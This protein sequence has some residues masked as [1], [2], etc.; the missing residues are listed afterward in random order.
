MT[1]RVLGLIC[2]ICYISLP[3]LSQNIGEE[4]YNRA[5]RFKDSSRWD[6][7]VFYFDKAIN[8]FEEKGLVNQAFESKLMLSSSRIEA[9]QFK[10]A[11][12]DLS[13]LLSESRKALPPRTLE[14][15]QVLD[16][17][18]KLAIELGEFSQAVIKLRESLAIKRQAKL[19]DD[20]MGLTY[21]RF[22][23]AWRAQGIIDSA[24][25]A[26]ES[27]KHI[28][29]GL[30]GEESSEVAA[31]WSNIA[32]LYRIKGEYD[33]SMEIYQRADS[34]L[35]KVFGPEHPQRGATI[36]GM[37]II[38][39]QSARYP[40]ALEYFNQLLK[41]DLKTLPGDSPTLARTYTNL[42]ILH[43]L[44]GDLKSAQDFHKKSLAIKLKSFSPDNPNLIVD[45]QGLGTVL[46]HL[47]D[48][49]Q[50]MLYLNQV[51]AISEKAYSAMDAR[52]GTSYNMLANMLMKK[53]EY[54][55]A[56]ELLNQAEQIFLQN[57]ESLIEL[58]P[59]YHTMAS[60]FE[61][62]DL[63]D[64]A[65]IYAQKALKTNLNF[66]PEHPHV[67]GNH[68]L[69][70]NIYFRQDQVDSAKFHYQRA[71]AINERVYGKK[72]LYVASS[73]T[74]VASTLAAEKNFS[75][76]LEQ[77][78]QGLIAVTD[79]FFGQD[80]RTNPLVSQ[81]IMPRTLAQ[82][83]GEKGSILKSYY[84][85][86][87]NQEYLEMTMSAF[88]RAISMIDAAQ[89]TYK[90][91]GSVA[92]LKEEFDL[93]YE[94]AIATAH[95][96]YEKT[97]EVKYLEE[98]F[99]FS[100]K[101]K[102][103]LLVAA[104]NETRAKEFAGI[105][106]EI[107]E[108][109]NTLKRNLGYFEQQLIEKKGEEDNSAVSALQHKIFNLKKEYDNLMENI[110]MNYTQ[111]FQLKYESA[112]VSLADIKKSLSKN[113]LL[114][115]YFLGK[116]HLY[117]FVVGES[118]SDFI[119]V[120]VD[121]NFQYLITALRSSLAN[122]H[123]DLASFV[124]TS[125]RLFATLIKPY[126]DRLNKQDITF[127]LDKE[128]G[129]IPFEILVK[130]ESA[131]LSAQ[132]LPYLLKDHAISYAYSATFR[133]Q[134]KGIRYPQHELR[135]VA[136]APNFN[137]RNQEGDLQVPNLFAYNDAMRGGLVELQGAEREVESLATYFE[138]DYYSQLDA[139]ESIFKSIGRDYGIIHLATHAI[140]DDV[141]P[142]NSRLLF[143]IDG[144][145]IDDGN[146]HAWELFS[147]SLNAKLAVLSAC[148]TGFGKI[149]K[150]DGVQSLGRAFAY[151]GCPST[152]IS[153]WPAQD[154][155]TADIMDRFYSNLSE[156]ISKDEALQKAKIF[157]LDN[158]NEFS[159]H[160]FYW[161]GFI[162]QGDPEPLVNKN[163]WLLWSLIVGAIILL[164]WV[165][166]QH[167]RARNLLVRSEK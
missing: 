75:A 160:P 59:V 154:A 7:A 21:F 68:Q 25:T 133:H 50:A 85:H 122:G 49:D 112:T 29:I 101:N 136:F 108:K 117:I 88:G 140:I 162:L 43:E 2:W 156:G 123:G 27:A 103:A 142:L 130:S 151:A 132:K 20:A 93:V 57:G 73:H 126:Q 84:E 61:M 55:Q 56:L 41:I 150:G 145:S 110:E 167:I 31:V 147:M 82:V 28:R 52:L 161:A 4:Y 144:D 149:Q 76:A 47:G 121:A 102:A 141:N 15:A 26:Y 91:S 71:L 24:M 30:Y 116:E 74:R 83:L 120:A 46:D 99:R 86:T 94:N 18:G 98:A 11:G 163:L 40:E 158:S 166:V 23:D 97:N 5:K 80:F 111:Y 44:M 60:I 100:E 17:Q 67:A 79:S 70:G 164:V 19:D 36:N 114:V 128:L 138:G 155:S 65:L 22:G 35:L 9:R 45:Y 3:V 8:R 127:I 153:L 131:S 10:Q 107:L 124:E 95:L 104:L 115:E 64:S 78:Q 105:P 12:E 146:L 129:Y 152:L 63:R 13:K 39:A 118:F 143:T 157:Y 109:E 165:Y 113:G 48:I 148:N 89:F 106:P 37:A 6:S 66:S 53:G 90:S 16:L 134:L 92:N 14:I 72:N 96:L 32:I 125:R 81:T 33:K 77:V 137:G 87:N 1:L 69:I 51:I 119:K 54:S 62:Q 42:G 58:G 135:F 38:Y 34:I 139:H 159:Q